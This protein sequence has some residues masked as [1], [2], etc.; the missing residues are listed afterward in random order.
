MIIKLG[1]YLNN[2]FVSNFLRK[3]NIYFGIKGKLKLL[4]QKLL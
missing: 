2:F 4:K 3:E 1:N